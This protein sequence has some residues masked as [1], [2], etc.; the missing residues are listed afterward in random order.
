[1]SLDFLTGLSPTDGEVID[2][3]V[4]DGFSEMAHFSALPKL[5]SAHETEEAILLHVS[6]LR[7]LLMVSG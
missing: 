2:L 5:S 7:G 3:T 1:M 4:I 6:W